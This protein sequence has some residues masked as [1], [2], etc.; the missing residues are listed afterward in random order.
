MAEVFLGVTKGL[1]GFE[2]QV[3]IKRVLPNLAANERFVNMFLDEA[4]LSLH[5]NHANIVQVFD[6]GRAGE[7]YF[8]VMEF[9]DGAN[10]KKIMDG[11]FK[12]GKRFDPH[13]AAYVMIEVCKG[14]TYAHNKK[15]K[16]NLPLGVVHRDISPPNV[17]VSIQGE[18]KLVDFGLA[19][20]ESQ[21]E[22][23][24]AGV[25]KGK[26]G[27]LS[28]EA[29]YGENVDARTDIFA[30]GIVL[31]EMLS[32]KRLFRGR[33]DRETLLQVQAAKIPSI[34]KQNHNVPKALEI[35]INK[36]LAKDPELRY[37][38]AR[39]LG[40][41]LVR[42]LAQSGVAVTSYDLA[43]TVVA[44]IGAAKEPVKAPASK[45]PVAVAVIEDEI[46]RF[47]RIE[48]VPDKQTPA[49]SSLQDFRT[50]GGLF[51]EDEDPMF[52]GDFGK[53][54]TRVLEPN[55][56]GY[57]AS[58]TNVSVRIPSSTVL[59]QKPPL[60]PKPPPRPITKQTR[61]ISRNTN[62]NKN[63]THK[64]GK[65]IRAQELPTA[66]WEKKASK[67]P[68]K[69]R[70]PSAKSE[71][72]DQNQIIFFVLLGAVVLVALFLIYFVLTKL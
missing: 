18:V 70:K 25:V 39:N 19:K 67:N 60:R 5:L 53:A 32:G 26:F 9:I 61:P 16:N 38:T 17:L 51:D 72:L 71:S 44:A 48:S 22:S 42:F 28:P 40:R 65:V 68:P 37:Q 35:I 45:R 21:I 20:A 66:P 59:K 56:G 23:T 69:K 55:A 1:E 4:R 33:T 3:A 2:K 46:N 13:M 63:A 34:C 36:T 43:E 64:G 15:G 57:A 31:W 10:L 41:D 62:T 30:V 52:G 47:T 58:G 50:W 49:P 7:T 11:V 8:I 54:S 24:D 12:T 29:A 6:V 14:L 27:Y